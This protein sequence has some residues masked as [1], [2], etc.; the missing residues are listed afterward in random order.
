MEEFNGSLHTIWLKEQS[1]ERNKE[2][3]KNKKKN[4]NKNKQNEQK[5][6]LNVERKEI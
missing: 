1:K 2:T 4:K 6:M 3:K 5:C